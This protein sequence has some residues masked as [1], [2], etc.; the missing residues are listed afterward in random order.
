MC[1]YP[2]E[3]LPVSSSLA[4]WHIKLPIL[5][6]AEPLSYWNFIFQRR[7]P[8][9]FFPPLS[10]CHFLIIKL[11]SLPCP[12]EV[13]LL[14]IK[15]RFSLWSLARSLRGPAR[16]Y[17][18]S[19]VYVGYEGI[20]ALG[21]QQP[22]AFISPSICETVVSLI[23]YQLVFLSLL[24]IM[25]WCIFWSSLDSKLYK[26]ASRFNIWIVLQFSSSEATNI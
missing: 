10:K 7:W 14:L 17:I 4:A 11:K 25:S 26:L 20:V 2:R 22:Q 1:V 3:V 15:S 16:V 6:L 13:S 18:K 19:P 24:V 21:L 12:E 5:N 23:T 8:L 9:L